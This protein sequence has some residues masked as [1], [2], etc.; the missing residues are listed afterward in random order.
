[1][2]TALIQ[3][4]HTINT[5]FHF[6]S[7]FISTQ[8]NFAKYQPD[9][10]DFELFTLLQQFTLNWKSCTRNGFQVTLFR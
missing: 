6:F 8:N 5:T 9:C 1:M 10:L 3:N 4:I 7:V 2:F